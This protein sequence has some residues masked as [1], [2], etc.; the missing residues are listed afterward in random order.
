M[1][2]EIKG[3]RRKQIPLGTQ[4][5]LWGRAAGRCEFEGCNEPLWKSRITQERVNL[6]EK[7]HI[8]AYNAGG[9]R[10][11]KGIPKKY[12]DSVDNLMLVCP[13]CHK[14]IDK[15]KDGGRYTAGLL[16]G[17]KREHEARVKLVTG[18]ASDK[19]SHVVHYA[20]N[21]DTAAVTLDFNVT[22]TAMFPRRYPAQET[23]IVLS[24][25][26]VAVTDRTAA[27]WDEEERNLCTL[28]ERVH[29]RHKQNEIEHLSFFALA[30][31]P[32]LIR[33]GTLFPEVI[34]G[35]VYA[36]HKTP[37]GW[38]WR[39]AGSPVA[40]KVSPPLSFQ[41][42]PVLLLALSS[43]VAP[44]RVTT[45]VGNNAS[46]W[47]VTIDRPHN[48]FLKTRAQLDAFGQVVRPL[49]DQIRLKHGQTTPIH[50]MPVMPA[51]AA[52]ELGRI[53]SPKV[54]ADWL[55]YDAVPGRGDFVHALTVKGNRHD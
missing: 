14:K 44:E 5:L 16:Q 50:V 42:P 37:Q 15:Q 28:A 27:F 39:K 13:G 2:E 21:I 25:R 22:A 19:K 41:G 1:I 7:A 34:P 46:I 43:P 8:Y 48:D 24:R 55:L 35:D 49:L 36:H 29:E 40:F 52:V 30:P 32:L 33:L 31:Q 23:A 26:N 17:W 38:D 51:A 20:A 54:S 9:A 4:C 18:I 45:V 12:L 11:N 10:G 6:A 53:R 3:K 47:T